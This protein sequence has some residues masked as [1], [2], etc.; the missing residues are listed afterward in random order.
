QSHKRCVACGATE[1]SKRSDRWGFLP[2]DSSDLRHFSGDKNH[3]QKELP[4][5]MHDPESSLFSGFNTRK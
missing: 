2:H 3:Y 1:L 4:T 5:D